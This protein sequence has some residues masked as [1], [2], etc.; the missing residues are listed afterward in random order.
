MLFRSRRVTFAWCVFFA[1]QIVASALLLTFASLETWSL[2][3]G[4]L[5]FPLLMLM[6]AGEYVYRVT[7]HRNFPHASIMAAIHVFSE[8]TAQSPSAKVR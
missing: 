7:R 8:D 6:F 1:A 5:N 4:L 3:I 2:F